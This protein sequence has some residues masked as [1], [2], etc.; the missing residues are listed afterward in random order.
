MAIT[1]GPGIPLLEDP[2]TFLFTD[3]SALPTGHTGWGVHVTFPD[4]A[5]TKSLWGTIT[6]A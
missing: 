4:R 2:V 1:S 5:D 3:G 6:T